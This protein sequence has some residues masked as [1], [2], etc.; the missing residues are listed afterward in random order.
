L[1]WHDHVVCDASAIRITEP[2]NLC[3]DPSKAADELGWRTETTFTELVTMMVEAD[4][5]WASV[6]DAPPV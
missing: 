1:D 5:A 2:D 4:L 6:E 3:A